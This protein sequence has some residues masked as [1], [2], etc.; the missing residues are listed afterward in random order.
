MDSQGCK[1][2]ILGSVFVFTVTL[3]PRMNARRQ[4]MVLLFTFSFPLC[5]VQIG[6]RLYMRKSTKVAATRVRDDFLL[7]FF[8]SFSLSLALRTRCTKLLSLR[9]IVRTLTTSISRTIAAF[10]LLSGSFLF[11]DREQEI[12]TEVSHYVSDKLRIR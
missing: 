10:F 2:P 1:D 11:L 9:V 5:I 3:T 12:I 8:L 7:F 4:R 6:R